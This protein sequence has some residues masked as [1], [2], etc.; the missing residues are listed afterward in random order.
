[1]IKCGIGS[2]KQGHRPSTRRF[3]HNLFNDVDQRHF[4]SLR[5]LA[6]QDKHGH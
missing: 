4:A 5:A 3:G 2:L 6:G 1:M